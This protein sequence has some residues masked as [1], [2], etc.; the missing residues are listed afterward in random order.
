MLSSNF[1]ILF[2]SKVPIAVLQLS[3]KK[4]LKSLAQKNATNKLVKSTLDQ[5]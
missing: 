5:K 3:T 2:S 4:P 1:A